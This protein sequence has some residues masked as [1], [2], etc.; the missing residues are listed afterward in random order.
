MA[1][2]NTN[3]EKEM[4]FITHKR[5]IP[6]QLPR[7]APTDG[8]DGSERTAQKGY[9][10]INRSLSGKTDII[11]YRRQTLGIYAITDSQPV[12][13]ILS[14]LTARKN[15]KMSDILPYFHEK[16]FWSTN[17]RKEKFNNRKREIGN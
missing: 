3:P 4:A 1:P 2:P 5:G 7:A 15:G 14:I 8:S 13:P 16:R 12:K 17:R 11:Y 10:R 9:A 6:N